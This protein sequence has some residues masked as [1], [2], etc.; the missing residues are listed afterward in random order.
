[1]KAAFLV[2]LLLTATAS[3]WAVDKST[4]KAT[5][6]HAESKEAGGWGDY[7]AQ[8]AIDGEVTGKSSW[9][10]EA[11]E[12]ARPYIEFAFAEPVVLEGVNIVFLKHFERVY[13]IDILGSEN[14]EQWTP[15]LEKA[16]NA[17]D[18][19]N[20]STFMFKATKVQ[21]LRIVGYGNSDEKFKDW[22]NI[23]EIYFLQPK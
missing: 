22:T 12:G 19:E 15:L 11:H 9:R 14:G 13:T 20:E 23:I 2:S 3:L 16:K 6:N 5:A 17:G 4:V 18:G 8:L 10:G 21:K 7:P 1:M